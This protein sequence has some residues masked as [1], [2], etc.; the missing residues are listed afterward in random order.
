VGLYEYVEKN[1]YGWISDLSIESLVSK[2]NSIYNSNTER[3]YINTTVPSLVE[4]EFNH[5]E[6]AHKYFEFY[7]YLLS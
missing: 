3:Y 6:L 7:Q 4:D 2:L 5:V 1:K